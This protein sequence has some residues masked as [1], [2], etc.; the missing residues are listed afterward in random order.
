MEFP[1][2]TFPVAVLENA[3]LHIITG[4]TSLIG[5]DGVQ[6]PALIWGA[7]TAEQWQ[8]NRPHWRFLSIVDVPPEQVGENQ[9][10]VRLP[11][12]QWQVD[13]EAGTVTVAYEVVD[14]DPMVIAARLATAKTLAVARINGEA[15][16]ARA[17]Y[18]TV[19]PGQEGTYLDKATEAAA[20]LA[21]EAPTA[22][23]YPYL[24]AE[25]EATDAAVA[26]VATL[27]NQT[28]QVWRQAN[29]RIEGLRKG[30]AKRVADALTLAE[31]TAVFP[32]AWPTPE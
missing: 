24:Y 10:L 3:T 23:R 15:G 13:E 21:D 4:P 12:D 30:A 1:I 11:A 7:W 29:A 2:T 14:L 28:A 32:I 27:V 19:I 22:E 16:G 17:R 8:A 9:E 26:D 20:F 5:A 31:V 18:I 25:A 6:H